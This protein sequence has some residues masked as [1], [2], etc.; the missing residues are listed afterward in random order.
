[1]PEGTT[2]PIDALPEGTS[3]PIDALPEGTSIP[4]DALPEGTSIPI[5][6]LP[7]GTT[8]PVD[9]LPEGTSIPIDALPEGTTIPV[10][11]LPEGTSIPIDALPEGTTIPID[12]LP[13]GTS[14]PIDALPAG[15][16]VPIDALPAG[17]SI[18]FDGIGLASVPFGGVG[19]ATV[20]VSVPQE[21]I[22]LFKVPN[23]PQDTPVTT[24]EV[25]TPLSDS[26]LASGGPTPN[27]REVDLL[28][29]LDV[30][31]GLGELDSDQAQ[32]IQ[33]Q[34]LR[35]EHPIDLSESTKQTIIQASEQTKV[36]PQADQFPIEG[37]VDV[38]GEVLVKQ[39]QP[40]II[41][42][43]EITIAGGNVNI[44]ASS[45]IPVTVQNTE[46]FLREQG[47][48]AGQQTRLGG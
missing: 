23:T 48:A 15:T 13:A 12:A 39:K 45:A 22:D 1:M 46:I 28:R 33:A 31:R 27:Q 2:V 44:S 10:D 8:I 47:D 19:S 36:S 35:I 18:A 11:A 9:A 4:V 29:E 14:I 25:L 42:G 6:A 26:G 16:T 5:D 17:T 32:G 40:I 43:G 21:V 30:Y 7:E 24:P 20:P 34:L 38:K 37:T 3:I 41:E